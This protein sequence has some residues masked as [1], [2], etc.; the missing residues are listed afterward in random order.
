MLLQQ[1]SFWFVRHGETEANAA[2][3]VAGSLETPLTAKGRAQAGQVAEA[4]AREPIAAIWSSPRNR[5]RDTAQPL[6]DRLG[7]A[8]RCLE[9]LAE[10]HWGEWE[11]GALAG[12]LDRSE[13]P[14]GGEPQSDFAARVLRALDAITAPYPAV[15]IAHGGVGR[16]ICDHLLGVGQVGL[17][18]NATPVRFVRTASKWNLEQCII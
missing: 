1:A 6:A 2:G 11:G 18:A 5:A 14:P 10:R 9:D 7:L 4:L 12:L 16:V 8:V 15:I 13:T 17:L 3:L